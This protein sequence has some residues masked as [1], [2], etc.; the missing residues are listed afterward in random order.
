M[1]PLIPAYLDLIVFDI[2]GTLVH[3]GPP[4]A[5]VA[6]L[7]ARPIGD[8]VAELATLAAQ[9]KLAAATD[10]AVMTETQVRELLEP[11]GLAS[12]LPVVVTSVDAGAAKPDPASLRLAMERSKVDDVSRVLFVGNTERDAGAAAAVGCHYAMVDGTGEN[13][14]GGVVDQWLAE[15]VGV[16]FRG[17]AASV[18]EP[19]ETTR[20][21]ARARHDQLTKPQ[22]SLGR[23]EQLGVD[24]AAMTGDVRPPD[25]FPACVAVFAGDHGV[26]EAGVSPW[27]Q[28]VTTAMVATFANGSAAVNAIAGSAGID[29]VVVDV[30]V[31]LEPVE[32]PRVWNRRV[33]AGTADLSR[34]PAMT[35]TQALAALDVGVSTAT[36]LVEAGNRCLIGGDMGIGN[37]T[38]SAAL[39][40]A[41]TGGDAR[42]LTGRGTGIDDA[43]LSL[44]AGI[45]AD[46]VGRV[47]GLEPLDVLA[48][49]GGLEVAALAGFLI[50]GAAGRVPVIV[51]GV[52][53]LA[54]ATVADALCPQARAWWIAG[55]RSTEP[56]ASAALEHLGLD[57][58]LDLELRLGEGTGAALAYP[59]VRAAAT[60]LREMATM[61]EIGIA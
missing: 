54:A 29:V 22:G 11:V 5:A 12:L 23:L 52:I 55:H 32:H 42:V 34:G 57:P 47:D 17:A 24:L 39:I 50:G 8:A 48:E 56:A 60:V 41:L 10:T 18:V 16:A 25:P 46:A 45:V 20:E 15:R 59:V 7:V 9:V 58:V 36:R 51:D 49:I 14:P 35:R 13:G 2:G 28:E 1:T 19:D 27:P 26:L 38:P 44:K 37:T 33:A 40:T 4:T 31:A 43:T 30:G 53:A 3:E 61:A 21:E 6:D